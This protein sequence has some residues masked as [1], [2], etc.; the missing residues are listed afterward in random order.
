MGVIFSIADKPQEACAQLA[1]SL[2]GL[3]TPQIP[4]LD[5]N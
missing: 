1:H 2:R 4:A 5:V 3:R